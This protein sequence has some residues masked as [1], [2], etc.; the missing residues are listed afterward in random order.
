MKRKNTIQLPT[1]DELNALLAYDK[2][3]GR[4]F[5]KART[6]EMFAET[7]GRTRMHACSLWNSR[8]S[9]KEGLDKLNDGYRMGVINYQPVSAHRVIWKMV[10]GEDP[11]IIDHINGIRDDNRVENLRNVTDSVNRKNE[12]RRVS[13][14]PYTGVM[15]DK[16]T[17]KW[18]VQIQVGTYADLDEAIAARK[19]AEF[20]LGYHKNHGRE[21]T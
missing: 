12:R 7:T 2:E 14:R 3:T 16:K 11:M 4:L 6:P 17:D 19:N 18:I 5:W 20:L 15:K 8:W 10:H 13:N 9:G 1:Q 21:A